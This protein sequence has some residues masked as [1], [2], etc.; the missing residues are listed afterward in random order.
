VLF[1]VFAVM[2]RIISQLHLIFLQKSL[3]CADP[4]TPR[5]AIAL[6]V[7]SLFLAVLMREA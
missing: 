6:A 3:A 1:A 5:T 4:A 2:P 7:L